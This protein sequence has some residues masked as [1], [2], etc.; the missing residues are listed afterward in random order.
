MSE[1][2]NSFIAF[3]TGVLLGAA[4][5]AVFALLFAPEAGADLRLKIQS[6]AEEQWQKANI[7]L[8]KLKQSA[9]KSAYPKETQDQSLEPMAEDEA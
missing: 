5:G 8:D 2:R 9:S 6:G 4:F 1:N 3:L 7:E